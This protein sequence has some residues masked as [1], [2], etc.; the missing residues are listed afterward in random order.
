MTQETVHVRWATGGATGYTVRTEDADAIEQMII[1]AHP[2]FVTFETEDD[3][4]RHTVHRDMVGGIDRRAPQG[5]WVL[6]IALPPEAIYE[7]FLGASG[8]DG[9]ESHMPERT[10]EP[11][12][13]GKYPISIYDRSLASRPPAWMSGLH[14]TLTTGK[15]NAGGEPVPAKLT[16]VAEMLP[17]VPL[18]PIPALTAEQVEAGWDDPLVDEVMA[19]VGNAGG[20]WPEPAPRGDSGQAAAAAGLCA[21]YG[22]PLTGAER[23]AGVQDPAAG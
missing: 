13:A 3:C 15:H 6:H 19:A 2:R 10:R 16:T 8:W 17:E 5:W 14:E 4:Q 20:E 23:A 11:G 21:D 1:T 7:E 18:P 12:M 22:Q 9:T